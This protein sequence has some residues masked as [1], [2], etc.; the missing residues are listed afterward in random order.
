MAK[1]A[2]AVSEA[3]TG[4]MLNKVVRRG[5]QK[6]AMYG[7]GTFGSLLNAFRIPVV[8]DHRPDSFYEFGFFPRFRKLY[9]GWIKGNRQ[10]N[11]GDLTRLFFLILNAR[12]IFEDGV[13]GDIVE[14]GV[15]KGNSAAV[16]ADFARHYDRRL[17]LFDTF[18]GFDNRD[19]ETS[20]KR[21]SR[22]F[23]DTS[24]EGVRALVGDENVTY[25]Q[26]FFPESCE[27]TTMPDTVAIAHIDCD[28]HD[29]MKAALER[30]YPSMA[31]GGLIIL[32]DYSSG[33]WPGATKAV[34]EFFADKPE[35]PILMPDKS[36]TA[37]VRMPMR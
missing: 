36:G 1:V 8:I 5:F 32:H 13:P 4:S 3:P 33:Y 15:Y 14:L 27:R 19:I 34:D 9:G 17:F 35:R 30:F 10:N 20:S 11:G 28:L 7:I 37:I 22:A 18:A 6:I 23:Q 12:Q 21:V 2:D 16:F 29:P 26:G 25:V 24:L 31:P